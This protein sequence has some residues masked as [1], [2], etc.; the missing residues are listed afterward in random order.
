VPRTG[1]A[2]DQANDRGTPYARKLVEDRYPNLVPING[3]HSNYLDGK[4][5][6][7][8]THMNWQE[9]DKLPNDM[10]APP[11]YDRLLLVITNGEDVLRFNMPR[12]DVPKFIRLLS[13]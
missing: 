3:S 4:T 7:R 6:Y 8:V 1:G 10:F 2:D 9:E 13:E 5:R 12:E 11:Q